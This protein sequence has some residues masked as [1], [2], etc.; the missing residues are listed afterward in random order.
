M[1][2]DLALLREYARNASE[3]AFAALVERHAGLVYAA[4]LR[5][6][7]D[8]QL[9]ED[10]AQAVFIVLARKAG[11]LTRHPGLSGWLLLTTRYAANAHIRA[12]ARRAER[13]QEAA[14]QSELNECATTAW[15]QLEPVL[16]EAMASLGE[17]DRAVV[18]L[19]Y[20]ENRT[21]AEIG[22]ALKL[23]EAAANKRALRALEKLRKFFARRGV[24]VTAALI[25]GAVSANAVQ[26]APAAL[27]TKVAVIAGQGLATAP[28]IT[29]LVEGTL[30]MMTWLKIKFAVSVGAALVA[31]VVATMAVAQSVS[32]NKLTPQEIAKRSVAAYTALAS[33]SDTCT[34]TASGGGSS[35]ETTC[36]IKLQRPKQYRVAWTQSGGAFESK[37]MIWS[38]GGANNILTGNA[39]EFDTAPATAARDMQQAFAM[40]NGLS[41]AVASDIPCAFYHLAYADPLGVVALG[42]TPTKRYPDEKIGNT[43]CYVMASV[44]DARNMQGDQN[45]LAA[46]V[47]WQGVGA[48]TNS[49]WIGK[50]DHLVRKMK[51][52]TSAMTI[53]IHWTDPMLERQLA[54]R[55]QPATPE[56]LAALRVEMNRA[57]ELAGKTGV[58]FTE[59]HENIV[60]NHKYPSS[61]FTR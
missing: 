56:N 26:A 27:V 9:A 30:K 46:K 23:N 4:A 21:A 16:D 25:A 49:F 33:Y 61:D 60:I 52:E 5:Q 12:A 39:R 13:E 24:A 58:V 43:E 55:N 2:D 44:L 29:S 28:T 3:G 57:Q 32:D 22:A 47:N 10:V 14:M 18:A 54:A 40:A 19:R 15:P 11:R 59:T 34:G 50:R 48:I 6:V 17:T 53:D 8:P 42:R 20:F 35:T 51:T 36:T 45:S 31:G 38:D 41:G 37:S 1:M 7:R